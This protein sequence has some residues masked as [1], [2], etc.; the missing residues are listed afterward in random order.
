MSPALAEAV[1]DYLAVGDRPRQGEF[2]RPGLLA[3]GDSVLAGFDRVVRER[4]GEPLD[5][6]EVAG[7]LGVSMRTL[8]RLT[9]ATL[10]TTPIGYAQ[11]LRLE[12]AVDLLRTT[13]Q[14]TAAVARAAGYRDATTRA[15]L[16]RKRRGPRRTRCARVG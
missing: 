12:R 9:A 13:D 4:I 16:L 14:S 3:P 15:T 5:L 7:G 1:S 6:A 8:Q 2:V 11:H 10:G